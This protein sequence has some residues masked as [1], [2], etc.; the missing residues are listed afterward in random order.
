MPARP[1]P[2]SFLPL[3]T[4]VFSILLALGGGS[5]HPYGIMQEID[6]R[7]GGRAVILPGTLYTSIARMLSQG[8]IEESADRPEPEEDDAR[9]RYYKL[10]PLGRAVAAAE[11]ERMA[12][13]LDVARENDIAPALPKRARASGA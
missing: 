8:L 2:N 12:I 7:T 4:P 9:R 5:R 13:L 3:S 1:V 6:Q 10:T 11:A